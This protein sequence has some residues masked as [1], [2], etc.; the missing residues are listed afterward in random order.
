MSC[1]SLAL[2]FIFRLS[3]APFPPEQALCTCVRR[4]VGESGSRRDWEGYRRG[5]TWHTSIHEAMKL[6]EARDKLVFWFQL[7]GDLDKEGC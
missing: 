7:A 3:Q 1:V 4:E 6:A 5:I 2:L